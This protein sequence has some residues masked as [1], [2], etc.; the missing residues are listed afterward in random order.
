MSKMKQFMEENPGIS[1][2]TFFE[3][4]AEG[5]K[6]LGISKKRTTGGSEERMEGGNGTESNVLGGGGQK[7]PQEEAEKPRVIKRLLYKDIPETIEY[8]FRRKETAEY[9]T[10]PKKHKAGYD[11]LDVVQ[12][13]IGAVNKST[14]SWYRVLQRRVAA[15]VK[16]PKVKFYRCMCC[17]GDFDM[18]MTTEYGRFCSWNCFEGWEEQEKAIEVDILKDRYSE[19]E[20]D[21]KGK[22]IQ[23]NKL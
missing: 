11:L 5:N 1:P 19:G 15:I 13:Q 18:I 20:I 12:K 4:Q 16:V 14:E 2:D 23:K 3:S 10:I 21:I 22:F 17:G 7:N 8:H 6:S 9:F